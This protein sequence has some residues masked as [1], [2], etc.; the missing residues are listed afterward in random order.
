[1]CWNNGFTVLEH[2]LEAFGNSNYLWHFDMI[3]ERYRSFNRN[4]FYFFPTCE[5]LTRDVPW[6]FRAELR[7]LE[8]QI[9]RHWHGA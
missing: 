6:G 4:N 7:D 2:N 3:S 1:M 5:A 9:Y 8:Y